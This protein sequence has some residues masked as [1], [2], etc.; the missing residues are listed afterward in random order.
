[1]TKTKSTY[2]ALVAVLLSPM[3]ANADVIITV[4]QV[5]D[6][7][8]FD[9]SGS[10]DLTGSEFLGGIG[11]SDGFISGGSNWY[12]ASGDGSNVDNYAMTFFDGPFG[13]SG[14]FFSNPSS[15]FGDDFF[16]WGNAGNIAQVGVAVGY[17]S[18]DAINSGMIFA[19]ATIASLFM[20]EGT[21][22]YGIANDTI[23]LIIGGVRA[24]PEPGILALLGIGL[25][26]IGLARRRRS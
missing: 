6:D 11:Y 18:G 7:V 16:I 22:N 25:F 24:V 17:E 5:G 10:L 9:I 20:T 21:Y 4:D 14:T 23:T 13:T 2:L 26:G 8:V 3:A 19:D 1:M 12:I 15:V